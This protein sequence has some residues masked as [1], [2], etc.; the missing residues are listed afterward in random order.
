M[1]DKKPHLSI[2]LKDR[3]KI[4]IE[5]SLPEVANLFDKILSDKSDQKFVL[6]KNTIIQT[7]FIDLIHWE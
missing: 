5:A 3:E 7:K 2:Y 4:E 1:P 6:F